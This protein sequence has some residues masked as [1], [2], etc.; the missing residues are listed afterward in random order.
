MDKEIIK[1]IIKDSL[2]KNLTTKFILNKYSLDSKKE[3][4][5][6]INNNQKELK[7]QQKPKTEEEI[8]NLKLIKIEL[9]K[10]IELLK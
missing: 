1:Q 6:I 10:T 5:N 3:L 4:F 8:N 7:K 2:N 9:N